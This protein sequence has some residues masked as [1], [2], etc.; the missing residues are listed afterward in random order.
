MFTCFLSSYTNVSIFL[1]IFLSAFEYIYNA[2]FFTSMSIS[3]YGFRRGYTVIN[4]SVFEHIFLHIFQTHFQTLYTQPH[5]QKKDDNF[6]TQFKLFY[7]FLFVHRI[8][9]CVSRELFKKL[10]GFIR[11]CVGMKMYTDYAIKSITKNA[12]FLIK[13]FH[14]FL[15]IFHRIYVCV[16][17]TW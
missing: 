12:I 9:M 10:P 7:M 13:F 8:F 16:F 14:N 6:R 15:S 1:Y 2:F 17:T 4:F 11:V 5:R 3:K